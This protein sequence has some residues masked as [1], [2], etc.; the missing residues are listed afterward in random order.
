M[1]YNLINESDF[2]RRRR[3]RD[4]G[5]YFPITHL[6]LN[7]IFCFFNGRLNDFQMFF[8]VFVYCFCRRG[9]G[10][11]DCRGSGVPTIQLLQLYIV[12][13]HLLSIVMIAVKQRE[14]SS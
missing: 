12:R 9:R 8:F 3:R 6:P 1:S 5:V 7:S 13:I 11:R 4:G 14:R 2:F 10:G